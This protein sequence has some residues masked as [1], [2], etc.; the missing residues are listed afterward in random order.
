[1]Y[2]FSLHFLISARIP[3]FPENRITSI[4][5]F[6]RKRLVLEKGSIHRLWKGRSAGARCIWPL[7]IQLY[8]TKRAI[9]QAFKLGISTR[10]HRGTRES[11]FLNAPDLR[12]KSDRTFWFSFSKWLLQVPGI[13]WTWRRGRTSDMKMRGLKNTRLVFYFI[14]WFRKCILLVILKVLDNT[15]LE[16]IKKPIKP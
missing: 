11:R 12:A 3:T 4:F 2:F 16:A 15:P 6:P 7:L 10:S 1:M 9:S 13:L 14:T 8:K 5:S